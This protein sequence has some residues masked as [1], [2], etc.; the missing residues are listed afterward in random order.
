MTE[1]QIIPLPRPS[2]TLVVQPDGRWTNGVDD[3]FCVK[4][5][6]CPCSA[7][8][9][10]AVSQG[11]GGPRSEPAPTPPE[12]KRPLLF[13]V[14]IF[15]PPRKRARKPKPSDAPRVLEPA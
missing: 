3:M 6:P 4:P 2:E 11:L 14:P 10:L 7:P 13:A 12:R 15:D 9:L 8:C 5:G 1:R